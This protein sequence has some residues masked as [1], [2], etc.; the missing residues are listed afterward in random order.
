[1]TRLLML[2][3]LTGLLTLGVTHEADA[4]T[5][6]ATGCTPS[7]KYIEP[8]TVITGAPLAN[9]TDCKVSYTVAVG[10][11][12]PGPV[13]VVTV[14]ASSPSGGG[15]INKP[16]TDTALVPG[17]N[18]TLAG[19]AACTNSAGTGPALPFTPL[20]IQRAGEVPPAAGTGGSFE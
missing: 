13:K 3:L 4:Y 14:P 8:T 19:G 5:C 10:T 12:A 9:L 17:F 18:Y 16:F 11:A 20:V 1:M 7:A 15:S 2:L 6:T